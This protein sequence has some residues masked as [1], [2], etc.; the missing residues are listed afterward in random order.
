MYTYKLIPNDEMFSIIPLLRILND[1]ISEEILRERL[2]EMI[3]KEYECLGVFDKDKLIGICGIWILTKY[4]VG[5]HIEP[6]NVMVLPEYRGSG[7]GE[8]MMGWIYEY[9]RS[10]GCIATELNCYTANTA[11]QKFWANQNY[12]IVGF[13]YQRAL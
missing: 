4:Y 8:K 10:K 7:I 1:K 13:H 6:D 2:A 9:G 11:G 5:R 12:K 3:Q